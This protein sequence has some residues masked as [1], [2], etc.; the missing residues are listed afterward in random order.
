ML[1][2]RPAHCRAAPGEK[3]GKTDAAFGYNKP[4][5][6]P[7]SHTPSHS[8]GD[9]R[10]TRRE[11]RELALRMLFQL[12]LGHQPINDV[13]AEALTQSHLE[14]GNRQYAE[15]LVRGALAHR[16]EID[17]RLASLT[18]DWASDRQAV[19]DRN[20]LRLAAYELLHRPD[21]PVAVV[22]NEAVE[23]AK[24]YSTADSGR[25]VNGVLG[26][27]ARQPRGQ[28]QEG[29]GADADL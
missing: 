2:A 3:T 24:K 13:I 20:I 8:H 7:D 21:A 27:L 6:T 10:N 17:G 22:V 9:S 1:A 12:D 18:T 23:L 4:T 19:V 16:A 28:N 26:A 29:D 25:F 5:M 11:S 15:E 14:G